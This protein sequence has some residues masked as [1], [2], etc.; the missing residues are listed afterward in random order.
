MRREGVRVEGATRFR[1]AGGEEESGDEELGMR[2]VLG[3]F[4]FLL[5]LG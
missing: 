5:G 4:Y 1:G 2:A 3:G